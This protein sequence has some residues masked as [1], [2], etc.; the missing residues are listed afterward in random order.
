MHCYLSIPIAQVIPKL[1]TS[2]ALCLRGPTATSMRQAE[3]A[4]QKCPHLNSQNCEY[5]IRRRRIKVAN[6]LNLK[7]GDFPTLAWW[8]QCNHKGP[9]KWKR[10]VGKDSVSEWCEVSQTQLVHARFE[11]G[12]RE[13]RSMCVQKKLEKSKK[14]IRH[15]A[16]RKKPVL[17]S[18]DFSPVRPT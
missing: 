12:G 6:Q 4:P 3:W 13:P 10:E 8:A 18:L 17:T 1:S 14:Q 9:W 15:R 16:Y 7:Q 5:V 11:D 2:V